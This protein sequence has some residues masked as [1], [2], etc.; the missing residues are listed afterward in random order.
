M[1]EARL[2]PT[3]STNKRPYIEV[4]TGSGGLTADPIGL[5]A[6]MLRLKHGG[7]KEAEES[8]RKLLE[9]L[10]QGGHI[11]KS[12][13][14]WHD[15]RVSRIYGFSVDDRG[16]IKYSSPSRGSPKRT[17]KTYV[18][19]VPDVDMSVLRNAIIRSKQMAI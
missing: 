3:M 19:D 11:P 7:T 17:A 8:N 10:I 6:H 12:S 1:R 14:V 5:F 18:A 2:Q 16:R 13:I 9:G 4:E 15:D